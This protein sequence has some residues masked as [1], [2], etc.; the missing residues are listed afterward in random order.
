MRV[1]CGENRRRVAVFVAA[2]KRQIQHL[3]RSILR[4]KHIIL[5]QLLHIFVRHRRF[6]VLLKWKVPSPSVQDAP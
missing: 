5:R 4:I 3:F 2:V 1:Q 6:V